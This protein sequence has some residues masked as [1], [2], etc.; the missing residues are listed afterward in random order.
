MRKIPCLTKIGYQIQKSQAKNQFQHVCPDNSFKYSTCKETIE[1][2]QK[3][4]HY[5]HDFHEQ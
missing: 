5:Q 2:N 3:H 1:I 4:C